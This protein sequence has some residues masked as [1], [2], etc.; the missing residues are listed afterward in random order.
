MTSDI[1]NT[2]K[3]SILFVDDEQGVL[4][5]LSRISHRKAWAATTMTSPIEAL[6]LLDD[7]AFDVVVCDMR[8]PDMTGDA[9]LSIAREQCPNMVRVL[10]TGY[11]DISAVESAVNNAKIFNYISKPWDD[12]KLIE[13]IEEAFNESERLKSKIKNAEF[14]QQN[15]QKLSRLALLLDKKVK[16][17]T[18]EIDQALGLL[19]NLHGKA[20]QNFFDALSVTTQMLEWKEGQDAG[21]VKFVSEYGE[22]VIHKLKWTKGGL[23]SLKLAATLHRIGLM[24]LPDDLN[25][26]PVFSFNSE[27]RRQYE[28]APVWSELALSHAEGLSEIAKIVRHQHEYINGTG[29]PDNLSDRE[30]PIISKILSALGD[31]YDLYNGRLERNM[32]GTAD[33]VSY[34]REW[35]GKKYDS[36]VVAAL[37]DV[38]G[39]FGEN[40]P[41]K[42][43]VKT[44][45]LTPG[46]ILDTDILDKKNTLLLSRGVKICTSHI[47]HLQQYERK[48]A[49]ALDI[50]VLSDQS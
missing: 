7:R 44:G 6:S 48:H 33:A 47:K 40:T 3:K 27:E 22:K 41:N 43:H 10:I 42:L 2:E 50:I 9:F 12:E 15:N 19:E 36:E 35:S 14:S 4:N 39:D 26:R 17:K 46:M 11:S 8:M 28:Q 31:F 16:E 25:Q 37:L 1:E 34:L 24:Y 21:H 45:D 29:Y 30:I 13:T 20:E 5:A 18:I 32:S 49:E 38:L 23:D